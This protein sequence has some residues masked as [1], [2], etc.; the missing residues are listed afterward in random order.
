MLRITRA[1]EFS[2]MNTEQGFEFNAIKRV[3]FPICLCV[4]IPMT[5]CTEGRWEMTQGFGIFLQSSQSPYQEWLQAP[6]GEGVGVL[7]QL[8][9][10]LGVSLD[11]FM[12]ILNSFMSQPDDGI[13]ESSNSDYPNWIKLLHIHTEWVMVHWSRL[14]PK[15]SPTARQPV[16][17]MFI[18]METLSLVIRLYM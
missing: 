1:Y 13:M 6:K 10:Y 17:P 4:Y 7:S 3:S 14:P 12:E 15:Q 8:K 11:W 18:D 2:R 9:L 5:Q 16:L